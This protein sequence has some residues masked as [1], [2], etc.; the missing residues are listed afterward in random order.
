MSEQPDLSGLTAPARLRTLPGWLLWRYEQISGS[1]KPL[2]VPYYALGGRRRGKQGSPSDRQALVDF[3]K[4]KSKAIERGFDGVGLALMPEWGITALD[5]DHV[6]DANGKLPLE[7]EAIVSKT[8][9]EYSPSGNGVRAFVDGDLGDRKSRATIDRYGMETFAHSGFVTV[10]GN[11]LF[12]TDIFGLSD[13]IA[14]ID[15]PLRALCSTRFAPSERI[16]SDDDWMAGHEPILGL[17]TP[18]I[19]SYLTRLDPSMGREDWIKVGMAIHH[20]TEGEGFDLWD[21]WSSEGAQYPGS[22]AL[23]RQWD[24]FTRRAKSGRQVTMATVIKMA[25]ASSDFG[26]QEIVETAR[27]ANITERLAATTPDFAGRFPII[28]GGTFARRDPPT[29]IIKGVLPN[30]DLGVL[31]GASGAG[32][33][34]MALDMA[35]AIARGV[36]WRGKRVK[37]GPVLYLAAEGGGGVAMRLAAYAQKHGIDLDD[38]P[39][40]IMHAVPNFLIE[41]D[42]RAVVEALTNAGNFDVVIIDTFAQVTAGGNENSGEDMGLAIKHART[43]RDAT[44]AMPILVHHSGKDASKGARGHSSLR[45]ATDVEFEVV[46]PEEGNVRV[47]RVSKQKDGEDDVSWGFTLDQVILGLDD[48][49]DDLTSLV[50]S[51]AEIPKAEPRGDAKGRKYS[52]TE[53]IILDAL[54]LD[55]A[56]SNRVD[57][58]ALLTSAVATMI[59]PG[60]DERDTRRQV[61]K[62]A[63]D[64][65]CKG[66]D[67]PFLL[68]HGM[69]TVYI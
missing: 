38:V 9:A 30:A 6:F 63:L 61:L 64:A 37:Q 12:T 5:F 26:L 31:Y 10:T 39:I 29:W 7:V 25:K 45:A 48:D 35:L 21:A 69:L 14:P 1:D 60:P 36:P 43:I 58:E 51:E 4:A 49:G 23:E 28:H 22:D 34:F 41:E 67:S 11:Q 16:N 47:M 65:M 46:R 55:F 62:R 44:G 27:A 33:S 53:R 52:Q 56:A 19:E 8:Y 20:E 66:A 40:G 13:T 54:A 59:E 18:D 17:T 15:E 24:S 50:V 42:I 57:P 2:K 32:K 68:E 3:E